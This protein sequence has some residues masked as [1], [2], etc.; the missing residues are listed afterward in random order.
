VTRESLDTAHEPRH[1]PWWQ[2][3]AWATAIM[4]L[5]VGF[6]ALALFVLASWAAGHFGSNK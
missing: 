1:T 4:L 3:L 5:V 6:A 2:V